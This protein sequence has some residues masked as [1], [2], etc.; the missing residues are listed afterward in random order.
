GATV[1]K[2][3]GRDRAMKGG[4]GTA[5]IRTGAGLVVGALAVVNCLGSVV[6]PATG[7]TVAGARNA[8]GGLAD[9]RAVVRAGWNPAP[10]F[11]ESTTLG[12]VA[13]N[14][15]ITKAQA[16]QVARMAQDGLA[17]AIYPAHTPADGDVVFALATGALPGE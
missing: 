6:D 13:T 10:P 15:R 12:V 3:L 1:G 16:T 14:A 5:S 9:M 17:R 4:L 7:R 11:A 2:A 8:D